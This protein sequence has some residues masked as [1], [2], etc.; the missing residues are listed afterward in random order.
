[1]NLLKSKMKSLWLEYVEYKLA[2]LIL[3]F[4]TFNARIKRSITAMRLYCTLQ[5]LNEIDSR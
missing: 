1:M 4:D 5:V 2:R 3:H